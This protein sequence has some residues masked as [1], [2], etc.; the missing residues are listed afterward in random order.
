MMYP[1]CHKGLWWLPDAP[2][3]QVAGTL[4]VEKE[5]ITLETIG[6]LGAS[7]ERSGTDDFRINEKLNNIPIL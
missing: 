4:S 3:N 2:D 7:K 1:K 5:K 6:V